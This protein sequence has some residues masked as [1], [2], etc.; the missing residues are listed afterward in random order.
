MSLRITAAYLFVAVLS[1]YAWKD[2]FK[3]VCG[4]VVMMAVMEHEDMPRTMFGVQGL[5]LWNVLFTMILIAWAAT[6][7]RDG[8]RWD[9]PRHFGLVLLMYVG[10]IVIGFLRAAF[11]HAHLEGYPL[12]YL[13]SEELVNTIK[14]IL[15]G[16]LLFDGCRT[17]KRLLTA[18]VC[19]LVL[20]LLITIQVIQRLPPSSVLAASGEIDRTRR[21]CADMGYTACDM[22]TLLAGVFWGIMAVLQVIRKK[23]RRVAVLVMA[24]MVFYAQ[25]L[26]GGR[27]GYVAW[28]ATGLVLCLLKW[29]KRLLLAPVVLILVPL[30]LPGAAARMF[31]GFGKTNV[32]GDVVVDDYSLTSGRTLIWPYVIEKIDQSPWVGYGRL[33]MTRTGL[34]GKLMADLGESFPHP[35]NM[36]LEALIDN[37]IIG[38]VLFLA[39]WGTVIVHSARLFRSDNR[40]YSAVGGLALGLV[41]TQLFAGIG[42][43][44]FYPEESTLGVWVAAFLA[45]RVYVEETRVQTVLANS[46]DVYR[47][48]TDKQPAVFTPVRS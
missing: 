13:V 29:R 33:A 37:G 22:S 9:L 6:R 18:M 3:S 15:P 48:L 8:C 39:F 43:Q 44:H 1:A 42:S 7:H 38:L 34:A 24:I 46:P 26:T 20:Y 47:V 14:W 28:G 4:L 27:S 40:L 35:H 12:K 23:S 16:L 21:A 17:R 45:V 25:A 41:L 32:A 36:Y 10:V 2:W 5:N 19:L 11:D 31:E 30:V